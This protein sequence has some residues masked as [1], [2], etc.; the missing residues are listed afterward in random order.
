MSKSSSSDDNPTAKM[1]WAEKKRFAAKQ[2]RAAK[3][4]AIEEANISGDRE[5]Y[6]RLVG[7][8]HKAKEERAAAKKAGRELRQQIKENLPN[9]GGVKWADNE[10]ADAVRQGRNAPGVQRNKGSWVFNLVPGQMVQLVAKAEAWTESYMVKEI[11]KGT[12]GI[13]LDPPRGERA[14]VMFGQDVFTISCKKLRPVGEE[15]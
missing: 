6:E 9:T 13:L 14:A 2:A 1:S 5:E 8:F 3:Q 12:I 11:G 7:E 15:E 10:I 4:R